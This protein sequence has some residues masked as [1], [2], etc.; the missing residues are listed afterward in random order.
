LY[1]YSLFLLFVF[2]SSIH[3]QIL[4]L[5]LFFICS[6]GGH[7]NPRNTRHGSPD[8]KENERVCSCQTLLSDVAILWCGALSN[9]DSFWVTESGYRSIVIVW[10]PPGDTIIQC[11]LSIAPFADIITLGPQCPR[12]LKSEM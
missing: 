11:S 2:I 3:S 9:T 4:L 6:V 1:F 12:I 7:F 5:C 8:G 10:E